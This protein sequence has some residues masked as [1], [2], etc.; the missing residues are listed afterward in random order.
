MA[1]RR[2]G[3]RLHALADVLRWQAQPWRAEAACRGRTATMY[4]GPAQREAAVAICAACPVLEPCR[5]A[6]LAARSA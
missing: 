4:G 5:S 1:D 6:A 3:A 2:L